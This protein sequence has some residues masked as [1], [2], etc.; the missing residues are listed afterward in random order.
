MRQ[1]LRRLLPEQ[2][3]NI[4]GKNLASLKDQILSAEDLKTES[5]YVPEWGV[6]V[7]VRSMTGDERDEF[8]SSLYEQKGS[9]RQRNL[10]HLRARFCARV[11]VDENGERL[12]SDKQSDIDK[13]GRKSVKALDRIFEVG[14]RLNGLREE[15][16]EEIAGNSEPTAGDGSS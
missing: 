13:L 2:L 7:Y 11:M 12:F 9:S 1:G 4:R 10:E 15:D 16:I 5:V 3:P 8:E 6:T 14:Q